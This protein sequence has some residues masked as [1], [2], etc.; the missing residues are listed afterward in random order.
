MPIMNPVPGAPPAQT[1]NVPDIAKPQFRGV[2][3]NT[4]YVPQSSLLTNIEG[5]SWTVNYY[6]QV[7][8]ADNDLSGQ[9][10]NR[11]P[12]YQQYRLIH[13]LE[14]KVQ[15]PLTTT[16]DQETKSMHVTGTAIVY[17]F[18]IPLEGDMFL[19]DIDDGR[20]AVFRIT[21]TERRTYFKE[22]CY[23]ID[24]VLVDY[25][26]PQRTGDLNSKIVQEYYFL[27]DFLIHGQNPL[28]IPD[29]YQA[30]MDLT[31]RYFEILDVYFKMFSSTEYKTL[32]LPGQPTPTYDHFLMKAMW[33][34]FNTWDT[35]LMRQNR[36]LNV[37]GNDTMGCFTLWDMLIKRQPTLLPFVNKKA[38]LVSAR[39][40]QWQ[41][42]LEGIRYSGMD[43]VVYP[44]D[45]TVCIDY[46]IRP[47]ATPPAD[48][49]LTPTPD[50]PGLMD[51]LLAGKNVS[52]L[53][54]PAAPVFKNVLVDDY[55]V[56]SQNFY[57]NTEGQSMLELMVRDYLNQKAL[58]RKTLVLFTEVYQGLNPID[59][60][61]YI[62]IILMLIR[63]SI[64]T[65]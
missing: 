45:E 29:E 55:Y 4:R 12:V 1:P 62:P 51:S 17:P 48:A 47:P 21:N 27:R 59:R 44:T 28:L 2:T 60:F 19:A 37:D 65:L 8:G 50:V 53:A 40:F 5:S 42:M 26:N 63:A 24:Y 56:F 54:Y 52:V 13:R 20:E 36:L 15:T 33:D 10:L 11:D 43:Y 3:V 64:R 61:Y 35:P 9:Q 46:N 34:F 31:A 57:E 7:V 39:T 38:G 32:I 49:T 25:S 18:L 23:Q 41:P 14:L 22:S 16:Q 6:S 58:D 30:V